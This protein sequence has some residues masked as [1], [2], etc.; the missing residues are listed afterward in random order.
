[1]TPLARLGAGI[2]ATLMMSAASASGEDSYND[3]CANC[4][5]REAAGLSAFDGDLALFR[6]RLAGTDNMPDMSAVLT[7]DEIAALF[8]YVTD[9]RAGATK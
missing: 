6:A 1:M 2:A 5:G 4:H 3:Y 9:H 8:R 7:D